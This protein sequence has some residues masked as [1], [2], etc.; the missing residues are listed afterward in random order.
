MIRRGAALVLLVAACAEEEPV[1]IRCARF[2]GADVRAARSA[3]IRGALFPQGTDRALIR[4]DTLVRDEIVA[5]PPPV[6]PPPGTPDEA[7]LDMWDRS[8][9]SYELAAEDFDLGVDEVVMLPPFDV[10]RNAAPDDPAWAELR[11]THG[12]APFVVESGPVGFSCDDD[13]MIVLARVCGAGC[14][15]HVRVHL[16]RTADGWRTRTV[17]D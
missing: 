2:D 5:P 6:E 4:D 15:S 11:A 16:Q 13:A 17:F 1:A 9:A 12:D 7:L 10:P 3:A 8:D 14:T